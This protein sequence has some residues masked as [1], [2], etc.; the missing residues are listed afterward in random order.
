MCGRHRECIRK[1]RM[2]A[3][4]TMIAPG[5]GR[6]G[7]Y[8][9]RYSAQ[10]QTRGVDIFAAGPREAKRVGRTRGLGDNGTW[11][12]RCETLIVSGPGLRDGG[13]RVGQ[14]RWQAGWNGRP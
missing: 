10:V 7:A 13:E 14:Y 3:R 2:Y 8:V 11:C 6:Y 1:R 5:R 4:A 9:V 12:S